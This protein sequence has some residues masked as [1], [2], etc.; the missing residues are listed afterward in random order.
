M[1][2]NMDMNFEQ[3]LTFSQYYFLT[4]YGTPYTEKMNAAFNEL[5]LKFLSQDY[6]SP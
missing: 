1:R 2:Q 5:I 3:T 6:S 4:A